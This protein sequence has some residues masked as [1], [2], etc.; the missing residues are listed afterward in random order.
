[1]A[2]PHHGGGARSR[3]RAVTSLPFFKNEQC[4]YR[5]IK[6]QT[7]QKWMAASTTI[8]QFWSKIDSDDN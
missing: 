2:T 6:I 3:K 1:V 7:Q 8:Q 5:N 4:E